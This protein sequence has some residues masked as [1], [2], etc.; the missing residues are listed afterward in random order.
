MD[1]EIRTL[2]VGQFRTNCYLLIEKDYCLIIDPGDDTEYLTGTLLEKNITPKGILLT[3]GHIDHTGAAYDLAIIYDIPVFISYK[4][5][6]LTKGKGVL[7]EKLDL[8]NL[9]R[10]K[11]INLLINNIKVISTPGHTPGS[12]VFQL[13]SKK[14]LFSGDLIFDR[15]EVGEYRRYYSDKEKLVK[16]IKNILKLNHQTKVFAGHGSAFLLDD[17]IIYYQNSP[18][19]YDL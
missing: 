2:I 3:H 15:G 1:I 14:Y 5:L 10:V 7:L 12:V 16:S 9:D 19:T 4:D 11:N 13:P 18:L 17:Y 8:I 6:F